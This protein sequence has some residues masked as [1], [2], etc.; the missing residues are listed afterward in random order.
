MKK[1]KQIIGICKLHQVLT[2][3]GRQ[4]IYLHRSAFICSYCIC[5]NVKSCDISKENPVFSNCQDEVRAEWHDFEKLKL[6]S[7]DNTTDFDESSGEEDF[8]KALPQVW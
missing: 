2:K 3:P 6:T 1:L 4:W 7:Y 5:E 8:T